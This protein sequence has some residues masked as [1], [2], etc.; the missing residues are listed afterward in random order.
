VVADSEAGSEYDECLLKSRYYSEGRRTLSLIE[1]LRHDPASGFVRERLHL[2]R[3]A[4]SAAMFGIPFDRAAA[5][6]LLRT[7]VRTDGPSRMRLQLDEDGC[8][9][10][11]AQPLSPQQTEDP[12]RYGISGK[13]VRSTD[14]LARHKTNWRTLYDE[15]LARAKQA[16]GCDEVVFLNEREEV[17]EGS[18]TNIFIR[19]KGRLL[20]PPLSSGA[21]A[22][23][24]RR[25]LLETGA[26]AEAALRLHDLEAAET[27]YFGN[28]L[29]GLVRAVPART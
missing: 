14:M 3:M 18:R 12:W 8:L 24:L 25:E 4:E 22:G 1:T 10:M 17:V 19:T 5:S 20:T 16:E 26:C 11:E 7:H 15:E 28:S 29:R 13:R 9:R 23:C 27:V 2:E 6:C 21:L